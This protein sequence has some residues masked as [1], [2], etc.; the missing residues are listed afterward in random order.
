MCTN[1]NEREKHTFKSEALARCLP[2]TFS[3]IELPIGVTGN[4]CAALVDEGNNI[5]LRERDLEVEGLLSIG[6]G[7]SDGKASGKIKTFLSQSCELVFVLKLLS[8]SKLLIE[9]FTFADC[10]LGGSPL[11]VEPGLCN[12]GPSVLVVEDNA[13]SNDLVGISREERLGLL[14]CEINKVLS[15][16]P[17]SAQV[18]TLKASSLKD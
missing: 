17:F 11:L 14:D 13:L 3:A 10:G 12:V 15:Y 1:K 4:E 16:F 5:L 6:V 18:I 7:T 9:D 8:E 2:C